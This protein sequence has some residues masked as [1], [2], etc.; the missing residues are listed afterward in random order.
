MTMK[1]EKCYSELE[2]HCSSGCLYCTSGYK[3]S[4]HG[5]DWVKSRTGGGLFAMGSNQGGGKCRKCRRATVNC[6]WCKGQSGKSCGTCGRTGQVCP[7]HGKD[8]K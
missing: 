2:R 6:R 3:C 4:R 5:K 1:C 8:W 7:N